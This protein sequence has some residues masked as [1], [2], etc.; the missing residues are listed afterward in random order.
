MRVRN[1]QRIAQALLILLIAQLAVGCGGGGSGGGGLT[2][3]I[4]PQ[5]SYAAQRGPRQFTAT[6]AGATDTAVTWEV[7]GVVG[8]T[9]ATGTISDSGLFVAPDSPETVSISAVSHADPTRS[10]QTTL[11]VLAR[12]AIAVREA[13]SGFAEF[14]DVASGIAFTPRGNNYIRLAS[15][16][17]VSGGTFD[18]STFNVGIYDSARAENALVAMQSYGYNFV[19]VFLEV[20]CDSGVGNPAGAGVS[21]SYIANLADFLNRASSHNI[22]VMFTWEGLPDY[23]GYSIG[24]CGNVSTA[25]AGFNAVSLCPGGVSAASQ[26]ARDVVQALIDQGAHLDAVFAIEIRNEFFYDTSLPPLS[27]SSGLFAAADGQVYDMGNS[28]ARQ[29]MM[30]AGLIYYVNQVRAAIVALDPTALVTMGFF[31]PQTPNPSRIGDTRVIEVYPMIANSTADFADLHVEPGPYANLTMAQYAQNYGFVGYQ[32]QKPILMGEFA[33][34]MADYPDIA[35]A[36][37]VLQGWQVQSCTYSYKGWSL[38]TWDTL[39][40]EL[41][42]PDPNWAWSALSGAGEINAALAPSTRP[43]PCQ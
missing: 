29:Q 21:S 33:T 22:K 31:W 39:G 26:F 40:S 41:R 38:W 7:N 28:S 19:R 3:T 23:G 4:S 34:G 32:Q 6:V 5:V 43:N 18:H 24:T 12:H 1:Q 30:D 14:Y 37:T 9:A 42:P 17:D 16:S 8:G 27:W 2:V 36:A 25:G 10:A 15:L 13:A 20:C 11:T 35:Q